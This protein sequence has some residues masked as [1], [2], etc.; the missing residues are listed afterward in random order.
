V[1]ASKPARPRRP[2]RL[3][4][5]GRRPPTR[6][7]GAAGRAVC[8]AAALALASAA[9]SGD[10]TVPGGGF[11]GR[12]ATAP[13]PDR[14]LAAS[15][16]PGGT[17][18]AVAGTGCQSWDPQRASEPECRDRLR[19]IGRALLTYAPEPGRTRL[20]GDL[21]EGVPS[22]PDLRTWTYRLRAGLRFEDGSPI[23]AGDVEYGVERA[24]A[25]AAPAGSPASH[26]VALLDDPSAPYPG[27]YAD[28]D[29]GGGG[30][31][32]VDTPDDRTITFHLAR[33]FA[34]WNA[35]MATPVST[36][37]PP[38]ADSVAD[39]GAGYGRHPVASGPYRL[40]TSSAD[41]S[42]SLLRNPQWDPD[43]DPIRA[44]LPDR[45]VVTA[46]LDRAGVDE[47]LLDGPADLRL[48]A[49]GVGPELAGRLGA[50]RDLL[51]RRTLSVPT[52][53]VGALALDAAAAPFDDVHCRRAVAW[54]V[55]RAAV[56]DARGGPPAGGE[57][58]T[59]V[60]PPVFGFR[61]PADPRPSPGHRG[62]PGRASAE[63]ASC[64]KPD[65]FAVRLAHGAS[66]R[67]RAQADALA[68][69]LARVGIRVGPVEVR[70]A[71]DG[72]DVMDRLAA[73]A[74]AGPVRRVGAQMALVTLG[75]AWPSPYAL[76]SSFVAGADEGPGAG[77]GAGA[78]GG[79]V[80]VDDPASSAALGAAAVLRDGRS[81]SAAW[82]RL[83]QAVASSAA[84]VP[85]V[86]DRS[87][88]LF[89]ARVTNVMF[90]PPFAN[91]DLSAVGVVP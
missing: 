83:D 69:S 3:A 52:G 82:S 63:L 64:G 14:V 72:A 13:P 44:A 71:R 74:G 41:G 62:D 45:I 17:L 4:R 51:D 28:P 88:Q 25:V 19:W 33:P 38:E 59:S 75:G 16:R 36:P 26:V 47:R 81:A 42:A 7:A 40:D 31:A 18:H 49:D 6:R 79:A 20:V 53:T 24:F 9:C 15:E 12:A 27:P 21:A 78:R 37:V 48:D 90:S 46:G 68:A 23:T 91:A 65:G 61:V 34:D 39:R 22:S 60:L 66:P 10:G 2:R 29:P 67:E 86:H 87:L 77:A 80:L 54:A 73:G 50:D 84:C 76:F 55:D 58:A 35:L 85:L 57:A 1:S 8:V 43:G 11:G 56:R 5:P 70:G 30:L 89:G 32:S